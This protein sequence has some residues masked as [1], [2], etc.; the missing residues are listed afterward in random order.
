MATETTP[1]PTPTPTPAPTPDAS[2]DGAPHTTWLVGV[3]GSECSRHAA[4]W[5][6]ENVTGRADELQLTSAWSIPASTAMSPMSPIPTTSLYESLEGSAVAA[7]NELAEHLTP[8]LSIPITTSVGS[9]GASTVLLGAAR[10]SSLLVVGT[11]GRGGF[12]RLALGSTSTQCATHSPIPVAVIPMTAPT[13]RPRQIVVAFDGSDNAIEALRWAVDFADSGSTLDC[14]AV[15]DTTPIALGADQFA[16]PEDSEPAQ[17]RLEDLA[18]QAVGSERAGE[19]DVRFT[20]IDGRPRGAIAER[21]AQADLLVVGARG[22]G[23]IGAALLGSVSTWLL[24]HVH[25]P[26]VVVPQPALDDDSGS[27]SDRNE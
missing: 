4:L 5:A 17:Q 23:A 12:A 8:S 16:F 14:I 19:V 13:A 3:D 27:T 18:R 6:A 26:M 7:V 1:A 24:H 2:D 20:F 15:W 9:G 10:H 22:L 25:R 21:A 11:R